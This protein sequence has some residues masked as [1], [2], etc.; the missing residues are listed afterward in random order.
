MG[1][2]RLAR[3]LGVGCFA[4]TAC[5]VAAVG[6]AALVLVLLLW[7]AISRIDVNPQ[8]FA[9]AMKEALVVALKD[10]PPEQRLEMIRVLRDMGADAKEFAPQL[11]ALLGD[12]DPR[13]RAAAAEA[14]KTIDP[15][16][17]AK[18]GVK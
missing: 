14:L 2:P 18:A 1:I 4:V 3:K 16:A 6:A 10:G 11:A 9:A 13:V 12:V 5:V 7:N 17:A 15:D 8:A